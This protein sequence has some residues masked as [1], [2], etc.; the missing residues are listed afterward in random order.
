MMVRKFAP[1]YCID[2]KESK[3]LEEIKEIITA[4]AGEF[5]LELS[6]ELP[7]IAKAK[8]RIRDGYTFIDYFYTDGRIMWITEKETYEDYVLYKCHLK[9]NTYTITCHLCK[10]ED[11][12]ITDVIIKIYGSCPFVSAIKKIIK[13]F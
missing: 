2:M 7:E 3:I 11:D 8:M 1:G 13:T 9:D 6:K 5:S 10:N 4:N 12:I